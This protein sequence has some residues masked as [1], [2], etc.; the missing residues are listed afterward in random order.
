MERFMRA[1]PK[2]DM[3]LGIGGFVDVAKH[4]QWILETAAQFGA[5]IQ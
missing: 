5:P 4:R 3:C 1:H 2:Q